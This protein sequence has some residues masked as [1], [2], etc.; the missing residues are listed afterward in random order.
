MHGNRSRCLICSVPVEPMLIAPPHGDLVTGSWPPFL[1]QPPSDRLLPSTP[2]DAG[3][4][5][6]RAALLTR[7]LSLACGFVLPGPSLVVFNW[8]CICS[9]HVGARLVE[10]SSLV[11][12]LVSVAGSSTTS[13]H[14]YVCLYPFCHLSP[15][16]G[17]SLW[18]MVSWGGDVREKCQTAS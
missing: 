7:G 14:R 9:A 5:G 16:A 18:W 2:R 8:P 15:L 4:G 3:I 6:C 10:I 17:I 1:P 13:C 12:Q 11:T